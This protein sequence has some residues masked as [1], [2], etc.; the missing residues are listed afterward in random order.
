MIAT[1]DLLDI[2]RARI[3]DADVLLRERRYDGAIYLCGYAVELALKTRICTTLSWAGYPS[4]SS[5]FKSYSSFR[6]HDL[7]V[8]LHLSGREQH[9]KLN[10]LAEWSGVSQWDPSVRYQPIGTVGKADAQLMIAAA[11]DLLREI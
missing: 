4:T 8:L 6:T 5:E 9:I 10:F 11:K 2:A 7:D 1:D 3:E